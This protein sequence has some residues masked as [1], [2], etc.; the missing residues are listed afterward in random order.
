[1]ASL[2]ELE[3][4]IADLDRRLELYSDMAETRL[5]MMSEFMDGMFARIDKDFKS[6]L[7]DYDATQRIAHEAYRKTHPQ[8]EKDAIAVAGFIL[9][10][11]KPMSEEDIRIATL[12]RRSS[13]TPP[14]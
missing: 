3:A 6:H 9:Q 12:M 4:R 8:T 1:M 2:E 14:T 5:T 10:G 7:T 11:G 13:G